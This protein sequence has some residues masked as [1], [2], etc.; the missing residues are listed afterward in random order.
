MINADD[1]PPV[2][3]A[4]EW[5][6]WCK[7]TIDGR[8]QRGRGPTEPAPP[9][10]GAVLRRMRKI[11]V[12]LVALSCAGR[13]RGFAEGEQ[14]RHVRRGSAD[15][16]NA[17]Q[18]RRYAGRVQGSQLDTAHPYGVHFIDAQGNYVLWSGDY[19]I[20]SSSQ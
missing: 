10:S 14:P 9:R 11:A 20:R 6:D 8:K 19:M 2:A 3:V 15:L 7:A 4:L 16:H 13:L 17:L 12:A 18:R 1:A 5:L